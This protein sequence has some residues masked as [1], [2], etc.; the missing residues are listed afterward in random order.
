MNHQLP[1][2]TKDSL[3]AMVLE[4]D[5]SLTRGDFD[6]VEPRER[7]V[8]VKMKKQGV[9]INALLMALR[10]NIP[11]WLEFSVEAAS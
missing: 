6:I 1:W 8:T 7:A 2:L 5:P 4:A 3:T 11:M 9:D 10:D